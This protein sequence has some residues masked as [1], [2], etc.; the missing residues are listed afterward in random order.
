MPSVGGT[1]GKDCYVRRDLVSVAALFALIVLSAQAV[2]ASP[3]S[4]GSGPS[5][6]NS[7]AELASATTLPSIR[8]GIGYDNQKPDKTGAI[9]K[10]DIK[11]TKTDAGA[12]PR[13]VDVFNGLLEGSNAS[14]LPFDSDH[15]FP[16]AQAQAVVNQGAVPML[17][18]QWDCNLWNIT[19]GKDN[20]II[21]NWASQAKAFGHTILIRPWRELN[22]AWY[23]WGIAPK[24]DISRCSGQT[25]PVTAGEYVA[26]WK[27]AWKLVHDTEDATNVLWVWN[28]A[29]GGT[30]SR[31]YDAAYPGNTYVNYVSFDSYVGNTQTPKGSS[32]PTPWSATQSTYKALTTLT[33]KPIMVAEF[34]IYTCYKTTSVNKPCY[35]D[36]VRANWITNTFADAAKNQPRVVSM[37]WFNG[38][39]PPDAPPAF[40]NVGYRRSKKAFAGAVD[41]PPYG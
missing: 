40:D 32:T 39:G 22:G 31:I 29:T 17:T 30:H 33:T 18:T 25:K 7:P 2:A 21:K 15:T 3:N 13:V 10:G 5:P 24:S 34:S 27:H 26:A 11:T 37:D 6:H 28:V 8:W 19:S 4:A 1:I 38:G 23:P 9:V 35:T 12:V 16:D 20:T 36:K 14:G 41:N